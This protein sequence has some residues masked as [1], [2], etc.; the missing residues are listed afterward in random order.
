MKQL[1]IFDS[2]NESCRAWGKAAHQ[3]DFVVE[4]PE[5]EATLR[6]QYGEIFDSEDIEQLYVTYLD[7]AY[8][9]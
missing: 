1:T 8:H 9:G 4:R 3:I 5:F 6:R 2:I 7:A